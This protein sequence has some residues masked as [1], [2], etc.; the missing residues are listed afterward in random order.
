MVEAGPVRVFGDAQAGSGIAL[1]VR[2]DDQ[3]LEVIGSQGGGQIDGGGGLS[4][5]AFLVGDGENSAQAD[6]LTPF[7]SRKKG[8]GGTNP[9]FAFHV[10]Q[11]PD[12]RLANRLFHVKQQHQVE[13]RGQMSARRL[14]LASAQS[15]E[16]AARPKA[17]ESLAPSRTQ[18]LWRLFRPGQQIGI[19][20][21]FL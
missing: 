11:D 18:L 14:L 15:A 19:L 7:N 16:I 12:T 3:D 13:F 4:H 20:R 17:T 6:I 5:S 10:K 1:R 21:Q 8:E 9:I 2:V